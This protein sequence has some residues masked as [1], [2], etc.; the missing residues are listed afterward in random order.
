MYTCQ[1]IINFAN[2]HVRSLY[3]ACMNIITLKTSL[4]C[5]PLQEAIISTQGLL[6]HLLQ[7][8]CAIFYLLLLKTHNRS[9]MILVNCGIAQSISWVDELENG[10]FDHLSSGEYSFSFE[11]AA[12]IPACNT[13]TAAGEQKLWTEIELISKTYQVHFGTIREK[14]F[15]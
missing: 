10:S 5:L 11:R 13:F 1:V 6:H 12:L 14:T 8:V 15:I 7:T 9:S 2:Q 4:D 3:L